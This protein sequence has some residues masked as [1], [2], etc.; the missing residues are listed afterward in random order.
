MWMGAVAGRD[1]RPRSAAVRVKRPSRKRAAFFSSPLPLWW[2]SLVV[3][4]MGILR[5]ARSRVPVSSVVWVPLSL[6]VAGASCG[7]SWR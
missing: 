4:L 6:P 2:R 3:A 7:A 5:P 1:L